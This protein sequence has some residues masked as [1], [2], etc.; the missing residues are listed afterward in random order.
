MKAIIIGI[1]IMGLMACKTCKDCYL[2][3]NEGAANEQVLHLG[4]KCGSELE[5]IDGTTYVASAGNSSRSY[6][7]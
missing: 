6:C 7:K 2:I 3:E 4:E 5:T 1:C